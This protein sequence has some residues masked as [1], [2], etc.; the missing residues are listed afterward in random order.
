MIA[1]PANCSRR[2][3]PANGFALIELV[4]IVAVLALLVFMRLHRLS[5]S[6][7]QVYIAV[8]LANI[9]Q[10]LR[11]SALYNLENDDYMAHP[12]W[13]SSL[14][15]PDGWAYL[16]SNRNR[17]VPGALQSTPGDC[18]GRDVNS[19]QFTNQLAYFK[20]GQVTQYLP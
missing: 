5:G 4:I 7:E 16:T 10:I 18:A 6:R 12:T 3:P 19:S 15:G 8:D 9:R 1:T 20:V 17:E 2:R 11:A 13:G 14:S